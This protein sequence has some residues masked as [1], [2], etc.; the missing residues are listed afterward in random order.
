MEHVLFTVLKILAGS[1]A[2][3]LLLQIA[4]VV[5][6]RRGSPVAASL[7]GEALVL[8]GSAFR[9]PDPSP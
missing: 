9:A 8:E 6:D 4:L 7:R 2:I 1:V 5:F 3:V